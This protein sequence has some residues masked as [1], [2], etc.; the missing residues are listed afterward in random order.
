MSAEAEIVKSAEEETAMSAGA[1]I[2]MSAEAETG[3]G[4]NP[5]NPEESPGSAENP[6]N[7]ESLARIA[8][9]DVTTSEEVSAAERG[10]EEE[11]TDMID[12]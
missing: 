2:A 5:V 1:V 11:T 6:E 8:L 7:P 12:P 9:P 10:E 4:E 3:I